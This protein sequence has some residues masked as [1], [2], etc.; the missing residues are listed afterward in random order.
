MSKQEHKVAQ[1]FRFVLQTH[2]ELHVNV[3][4][5]N[6]E[7]KIVSFS[8]TTLYVALFFLFITVECGYPGERE[9]RD[10]ECGRGFQIC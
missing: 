8:L 9:S 7:F 1:S 6:S 4:Q 10:N 2:Y 5:A 3:Q